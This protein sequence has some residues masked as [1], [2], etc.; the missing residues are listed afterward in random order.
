MVLNPKQE[1]LCSNSKWD[2][3]D[4]R[5][6]FLNCTLKKSPEVSHTAG[7]WKIAKAI[8]EK[9]KIKVDEVRLVDHEI[10]FGV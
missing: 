10:A 8:L 2:F 1:A 4:L 5:A 3:S 9:N 7:L 6:I